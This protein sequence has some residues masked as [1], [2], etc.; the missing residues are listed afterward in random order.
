MSVTRWAY[1]AFGLFALCGLGFFAAGSLP[2]VAAARYLQPQNVSAPY[3]YN[4]SGALSIDVGVSVPLTTATPFPTFTPTGL[5]DLY[6]AFWSTQNL[7]SQSFSIL[8]TTY[9]NPQ[10]GAGPSTMRL[11][12]RDGEYVDYPVPA[13]TEPGPYQVHCNPCVAAS[14][15]MTLTVDVF[16]DVVEANEANNTYVD[17]YPPPTGTPC[18]TPSPTRT[19]TATRTPTPTP[20]SPPPTLT[21]GVGS[22]Y[23]NVTGAST[24]CTQPDTYSYEF[25]L[26][27]FFCN[28]LDYHVDLYLDVAPD[29]GGPWV[30][31][32]QQT[33]SRTTDL[34]IQG[35]FVEDVAPEHRYY[36][37]RIEGYILAT[38]R[39]FEGV[40]ETEVKPICGRPTPCPPSWNARA[41][42]PIHV[43]DHAAASL[44]D[45]LYS[46]GGRITSAELNNAYKFNPGTNSWT[47]I[48]SMPGVRRGVS[49]VAGNGYIYVVNGWNGSSATNTLFRYDPA[50]NSYSTGP[51]GL[52]ATSYQAA[53][54]LNGKVYRIGGLDSSANDTSNV[55][56]YGEQMVA[57][58]PQPL[59]S[60]MA[61]A[62]DGYIYV[63]G[64]VGPSGTSTKTYRYDPASD[65]WDDA[66]IA[67]L[68]V[69]RVRAASGILDGKWVLA[70]GTSVGRSSAVAWDPASNTWTSLTPMLYERGSL[71]GGVVGKV[72]YAVGGSGDSGST[73]TT[74]EYV[75]ASCASPTPATPISTSTFTA[76]PV[77]P[78]PCSIS[79]TD[80]PQDNT[81]YLYVRCLACREIVAGYADGS[82]RPNNHVTRGQLAKIVSNSAGLVG[83]ATQ[84]TFED[85]P[86]TGTF[87][88]YIERLVAQG[89]MGGYPCGGVGEPCDT[90]DKPYF[91]PNANATRAQ[92]S[93]IVSNARGYSD[94]PSGQIFEDVPPGSAFYDWVQRLASRGIMGGYPCGSPGEPCGTGDKSYFR[95]NNNATR[96][97]TSKIVANTFFPGCETQL[98]P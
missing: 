95:P 49:A 76:T 98:R 4:S 87:H 17:G 11:Q 61:V 80:V 28:N 56:I 38:G 37:I 19:P 69:A 67:D 58:L 63:A 23:V 92:I 9:A 57:S 41:P 55:E 31:V 54:F 18:F 51:A 34:V 45:Y 53:A 35:S 5:P 3:T 20:T 48:A 90:G 13:F 29:V 25:E 85:V 60:A 71:A 52:M 68:P 89:V 81:F 75:P 40:S 93:K 77:Q 73:N 43:A 6:G 44:G 27:R 26:E 94:P 39:P 50:T 66:A 7:C 78:M 59:T 65:T 2:R 70:G 12:N 47:S 74:Q 91:R 32:A 8:L 64:G 88:L 79:F 30:T 21:P 86:I 96:G 62:M 97:Q 24:T 46:F 36:Q 22:C 15:P 84:Q 82:F 33:I 10:E 1:I 83:N 72:F 42:Y 14:Y 16:N